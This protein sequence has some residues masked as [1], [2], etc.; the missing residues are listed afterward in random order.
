[1]AGACVWTISL[2][3]R[4]FVYIW[5]K[6]NTESTLYEA[7]GN[8]AR[9]SIEGVPRAQNPKT[10]GRGPGGAQNQK[11]N[12]PGTSVESRTESYALYGI[13]ESCP[14]IGLYFRF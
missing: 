5:C 7:H 14:L 6:S 4:L 11:Q 10:V 3:E 9:L 13:T 1:M 8:S 2:P 12:D